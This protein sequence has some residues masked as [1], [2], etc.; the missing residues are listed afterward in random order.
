M[1]LLMVQETYMLE[2]ACLTHYCAES[3]CQ[4]NEDE[5]AA[6]AGV[7]YFDSHTSKTL[8]KSVER[9]LCA[10]KRMHFAALSK[11]RPP[12]SVREI[13]FVC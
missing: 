8:A 5:N 7:L 6:L 1:K 11:G 10:F 3:G 4:E 2:L 9:H 13:S 12:H